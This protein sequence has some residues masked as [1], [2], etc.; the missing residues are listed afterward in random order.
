MK[1]HAKLVSLVAGALVVP[2]FL[3]IFYIRYVGQ[4]YYRE[5][6]G[7]VHLMVAEELADTLKSGVQQK[8]MQMQTWVSVSPLYVFVEREGGAEFDISDVER[9]ESKWSDS[10]HT[11]ETLK[12][13]LSNP[14]SMYIRTFQ[15]I[16]SEFAEILVTDRQGRLVGAT[17]PT[18]D[19]LQRDEFWWKTAANLPEGSGSVIGLLYDE[20]VDALVIDMAFPVYTVEDKP[21]FLGVLKVSLHATR[22]LQK[23]A[24]RPW[25]K[26]IGRDLVLP[27]GRILAHINSGDSPEF[28]DVPAD[29]FRELLAAKD[30]WRV[31]ELTPGV[32]SLAVAAPIHVLYGPSVV[33]EDEE[34]LCELYVLVHQDL[35][36]AMA[37]V[38]NILQQLT[39]WGILIAL[40]FASLSYLLATHWFASP[41]KK[42]RNASLSLVDYIKTSEQGRFEDSWEI[43]QKARRRLDEL[44]SILSRDELHDLSRDF[45]RMGERMLSFLRRIEEKL[46]E[47][48]RK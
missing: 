7:L 15:R 33:R 41:I 4:R 42:L 9:V 26:E 45:I 2:F 6:Q 28:P 14:L 36:K 12:A 18:T 32:S 3:G 23:V 13:I 38:Q 43:Q 37:P 27:D 10:Q 20:S 39:I 17:N 25:N 29:A 40:L 30:D 19:Y 1:V 46:I 16:N 24:P 47:I 48:K 35:N 8:F 44:E 31:V 21:E 5:Q 22:F 11:N 34:H